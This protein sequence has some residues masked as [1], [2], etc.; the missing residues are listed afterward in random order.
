MQGTYKSTLKNTVAF[1]GVQIITTIVAVL[2][3]KIAALLLGPTGIGINSLF[4]TTTNLITTITGM[5]L[6]T[7]C[8]RDISSAYENK[9]ENEISKTIYITKKLFLFSALLGA[10]VTL[11]FSP[12]LSKWTFGNSDYTWAFILLSVFIF[13]SAISNGQSTI[14]R[15]LRKINYLIKSGV[16]ASICN[17]FISFFILYFFRIDGIVFSIVA[18]SI[19]V[20]LFS[21]IF[22]KKIEI[23]P[24][25][26]SKKELIKNGSSI[27]YLGIM[28]VIASIIGS[29]T[30][31]LINIFIGKIGNIADIGLYSAAL[32]ISNQFIGFILVSLGA[33]YFP[34]LSA[35]I[36]DPP[37]MNHIINEQT[38][39][40]LL[41]STPLLILMIIFSPLLIRLFL[42]K[43]FL[44]INEF[45][46]YIAVGSFFQLTAFCIGYI[47]FAKNDKYFYLLLEGGIGNLLNLALTVGFYYYFGVKGFGYSFLSNYVLYYFLI[48]SLVYVRYKYHMDKT[49][50]SIFIQMLIPLIISLLSFIIFKGI[51]CYI[52]SCLMFLLCLYLSF[53]TL[54]KKVS[55]EEIINKFL[56][57][58]NR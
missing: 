20:L 50:I 13:L 41:L 7:S 34:R 31:Y 40:I 18:S 1:G 21:W 30:R 26:V 14:F 16:Y 3:G 5:G 57:K 46:R 45:I 49:I 28:L 8:V 54:N 23:Q 4:T 12:L 53:K 2:R 6:S 56:K 47:S 36:N 15:G 32:S 52:I 11:V 25:K 35:V 22:Y 27:I 42:S 48:S 39:I 55:F 37:K 19:T 58:N 24:Q 51:I 29:L 43:D 17:L 10:I 9:I 44:I 33:D 38:E